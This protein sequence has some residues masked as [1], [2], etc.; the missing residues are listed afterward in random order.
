MGKTGELHQNIGVIDEYGAISN[1]VWS[2]P[3]GIV[4]N[5]FPTTNTH[6]S[7]VVAASYWELPRT[8]WMPICLKSSV[9]VLGNNS[10]KCWTQSQLLYFFYLSINIIGYFGVYFWRIIQMTPTAVS[11]C[12]T[13]CWKGS[14]KTNILSVACILYIAVSTVSLALLKCD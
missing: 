10:W 9:P 2:L 8:Y 1:P 6:W 7:M 5:F 11:R 12:T 3:K 14:R 13:K 4:E